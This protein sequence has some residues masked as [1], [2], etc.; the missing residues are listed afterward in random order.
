[1]WRTCFLFL[2]GV[3]ASLSAAS[4]RADMPSEP[5]VATA[6]T[7]NDVLDRHPKDDVHMVLTHGMRTADRNT[8][9]DFRGEICGH[10]K[11]PHRCV[12]AAPPVRVSDQLD[13]GPW[14]KGAYFLSDQIWTSEE[15]W[16]GSRPFIDHYAIPLEDGRR[17]LL[18]EL[19]WWP[20]V[21]AMKCQFM[22][23]NDTELVGPNADNINNCTADPDN[24]RFG[25]YSADRAK[26][27]LGAHPMSGGAPWL[28][29]GLKTDILDWGL[30]DA[31]L[32]LGTMK[33]LLREAIRCSFDD[34]LTPAQRIPRGAGGLGEFACETAAPQPADIGLANDNFIIAS[35]SLG[36][37]LLLDTFAA[38]AGDAAYYHEA[39]SCAA[40]ASRST[41]PLSAPLEPEATARRNARSAQSLCLA[42]EASGDLYFLAN[43]FSLIE[44][45]R[46][47]GI[48]EPRETSSRT[49]PSRGPSQGSSFL[50]ALTLWSESGRAL[51][52]RQIVAFSDPGDVLTF[53]LPQVGQAKIYNAYPKNA[54]RWLGVFENPQPA[55]LGYFTNKDVLRAMFGQ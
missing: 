25:W 51:V 26:A 44:L 42:L 3:A 41:R 1:M 7:I 46:A 53:K 34:I 31:V 35:H 8:W 20:L 33:T 17:L 50:D 45:G 4:A 10:L 19:N 6:R 5:S 48:D 22:V 2:A 27:L 18:H 54:S 43:Q 55:H 36:A 21:L 39:G 29:R 30:S 24:M 9:R 47:Q 12:S 52:P 13:L 28:N 32:S 38:A 49:G 16:R 40:A 37:F 11:A 15:T 23:P 14:P